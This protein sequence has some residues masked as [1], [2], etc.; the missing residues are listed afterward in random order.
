[1]S[2]DQPPNLAFVCEFV[3]AG[4]HRGIHLRDP[5]SSLAAVRAIC[6]PHAD[7]RSLSLLGSKTRGNLS[8]E[9]QV[10]EQVRSSCDAIVEVERGGRIVTLVARLD[11]SVPVYLPQPDADNPRTCGPASPGLAKCDTGR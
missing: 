9:R 11:E 1:M 2:A 5:G 6:R 10:I 4:Q 7:D 8:A 3:V